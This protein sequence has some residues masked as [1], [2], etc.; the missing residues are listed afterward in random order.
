MNRKRTR[1]TRDLGLGGAGKGDAPRTVFNA[2]WRAHFDLIKWDVCPQ[3][4]GAGRLPVTED[5]LCLCCQGTGKSILNF[6]RD[7][8]KL[9]KRYK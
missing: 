5:D 9:V 8:H 6:E 1:N 3:C 7:G 4:G 2:A